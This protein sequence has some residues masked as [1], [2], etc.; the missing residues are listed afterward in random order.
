VDGTFICD[1][2]VKEGPISVSFLRNIK[3]KQGFSPGVCPSSEGLPSSSRT[4]NV[5]SSPSNVSAPDPRRR[6]HRSLSAGGILIHDVPESYV[7]RI[8]MTEFRG[9]ELNSIS[10]HK[11]VDDSDW[12]LRVPS[13]ARL[14]TN[15]RS[16]SFSRRRAAAPNRWRPFSL[17]DLPTAPRPLASQ[18]L[19]PSQSVTDRPLMHQRA[20]HYRAFWY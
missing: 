11:A 9:N 13:G 19:P 4:M 16:F 17:A 15:R 2:I 14:R 18:R 10:F 5:R 6:G 1:D 8:G 12:A 20:A 7:G 3:G